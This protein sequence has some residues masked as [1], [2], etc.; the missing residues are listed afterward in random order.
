MF[1]FFSSYIVIVCYTTSCSLTVQ[2]LFC[3]VISQTGK[4]EGMQPFFSTQFVCN[5]IDLS[6]F[7][8]FEYLALELKAELSGLIITLHLPGSGR[9]Q[10]HEI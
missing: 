7:T 1:G 10:Y 4:G 9:T 5:D 3:F 2:T 6:E 8:S